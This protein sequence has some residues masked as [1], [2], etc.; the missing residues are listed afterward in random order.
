MWLDVFGIRGF[1]V[2]SC[3]DTGGVRLCE[4]FF[5]QVLGSRTVHRKENSYAREALRMLNRE[6]AECQS[7]EM[8]EQVDKQVGGSLLW[9]T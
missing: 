4:F 8:H 9:C 5:T 2:G 6:D 7:D 3:R 1:S